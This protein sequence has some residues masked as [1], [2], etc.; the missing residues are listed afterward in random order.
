[1]LG[2]LASCEEALAAAESRFGRVGELDRAIELYSVTQFGRMAGSCYLFLDD[3]RRARGLLETAAA[4]LS[5]HSKSQAI[6]LGNLA[7]ALIRQGN[8]DEAA[9]RLHEAIDVLELNRGGGGLN[10]VF[11]AGREMRPWRTVPV[12]QDVHDRLLN[13]MAG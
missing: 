13:L 1:M 2:D 12:V 5:D 7:L 10:I 4:A 3:T 9:G 8:P 6:V 11:S